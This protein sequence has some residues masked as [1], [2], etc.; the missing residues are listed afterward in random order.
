MM[1]VMDDIARLHT[2]FSQIAIVEAEYWDSRI[3]LDSDIQSE[4]IFWV[5]NVESLNVRYLFDKSMPGK[6]V[7][8]KGDASNSGCGSFI[9]GTENVAAKLFSP[10]ECEK[11]STWRELD[12]ILFSVQAFQTHLQGKNVKFMTDSQS[13]RTIL[14]RGSMRI[15]V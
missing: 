13:A 4:L 6:F 2:R 15:V 9:E 5:Q 12:N 8:I 3:V 14:Q 11:H 10:E 7:S 1:P